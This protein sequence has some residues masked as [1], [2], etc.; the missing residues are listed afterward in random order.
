MH[1]QKHVYYEPRR[2]LFVSAKTLGAAQKKS[3]TANFLSVETWAP[4]PLTKVVDIP[5][6]HTNFARSSVQH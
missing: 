6:N 1:P 5:N 4:L 2:N 3:V